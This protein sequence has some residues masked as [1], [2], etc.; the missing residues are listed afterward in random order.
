MPT[1]V[2]SAAEMRR[3]DQ[4]TIE[5]HG[6]PGWKLMERAGTGAAAILLRRFPEVRRGG[7]V[8]LAGKGNNGGDGFVIARALQREKVAV[9]VI[10]LAECDEVRG[11]A[12][13]A[14]QAYRRARGRIDEAGDGASIED[15]PRQLASRALVVDALFGTGLSAPLRGRFAAAVAAMNGCGRPVF[16]VDLPSGLDADRGVALGAAVRAAATAT[17]G[18]LKIA[19]TTYP[20]LAHAGEVEVVDIGIPPQA[21]TAVRPQIELLE[22]GDVRALVPVRDPQAHKGTS[23]HVLLVAGSR[24]HTGAARLAA[25]AALRSG[26][27]LVTLAGPAS[28]NPIFCCGGDEWMTAPLGDRDGRVRFSAAEIRRLIAGK[29][30]VVAGPGIGTHADAARLI[31]FLVRQSD[32]PMV[33]DADALTC[34]AADLEI[35]RRSRAPLVLTPHPGEMA[36]MIGGDA[37]AVQSDRIGTARRFA[38]SFGCVL[39]LKGAR[40]LIAAP[41]GRV[42]IN[43]TGNP[44][45][46]SGGMGDALAGMIG[47]F[48]AQ[49][50]DPTAAARLGAYVH[51]DAA[52]RVVSRRGSIGLVAGDVI[53]ELP[54]TLAALVD[55]LP[56]GFVPE[57]VGR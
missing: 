13:R 54:P 6:T 33:L 57:G 50:L 14:L 45:M 37:A 36:R 32:A 20:G 16:A 18:F 53:E 28:L 29:R 39:L 4:W 15:L 35:L 38:K 9:E 11:D 21:L 40:S 7:V 34:I 2:V 44:G 52:D 27:G 24:G 5:V 1:P 31:A 10:L 48:L 25:R 22:R 47:A 8:V 51:G 41:D 49:G 3:L 23:G 19:L 17:F 56:E 46:A 26:A 42:W 55:A 12:L 43:P 30:A